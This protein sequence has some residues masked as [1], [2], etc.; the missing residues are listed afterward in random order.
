MK[1]YLL[2]ASVFIVFLFMFTGMPLQ[3]VDVGAVPA[4]YAMGG[5]GEVVATIPAV[6]A[7]V[8]T[9]PVVPVVPGPGGPGGGPNHRV[10]DPVT[11]LAFLGMGL[12]AVGGIS[13]I[14][15]GKK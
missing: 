10:P 3:I 15:K 5:G 2:T 11:T 4:A 12:A 13:I 14:R 6:P 7:A 1:K 9:I 8:D